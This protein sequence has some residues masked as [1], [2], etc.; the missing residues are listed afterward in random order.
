MGTS[1]PSGEQVD[2]FLSDVKRLSEGAWNE[3]VH[4]AAHVARAPVYAQA[5]ERLVV[6][7]RESGRVP[8]AMT[9]DV[10]AL[11]ALNTAPGL[12]Q[13]DPIGMHRRDER[14]FDAVTNATKALVFQDIMAR[15]DFEIL[16]Y[17]F[18]MVLDAK[19]REAFQSIAS[20]PSNASSSKAQNFADSVVNRHS[21]RKYN[22]STAR[23]FPLKVWE[24][25]V[26]KSGFFASLSTKNFLFVEET[27]GEWPDLIADAHRRACEL[28]TRVPRI[29]GG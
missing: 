28:A 29:N 9:A 21:G 14:L 25:A 12:Q 7:I 3:V 22:V 18:D 19:L 5:S 1:E 11:E 10:Q 17:P 13:I 4:H 2:R 27:V 6:L 15:E 16:R 24:T 8:E 23:K 20:K 26:I